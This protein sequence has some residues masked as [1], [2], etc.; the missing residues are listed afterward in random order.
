MSA[1]EPDQEPQKN[2]NWHQSPTAV[3]KKFAAVLKKNEEAQNHWLTRKEATDVLGCSAQTIVNHERK[4]HLNP[5]AAYRTDNR[6]AQ[7]KVLVYDPQELAKLAT[8]V[9]RH[10]V[11]PRE[12]GELAARAY[13][14]FDEGA[15]EKRIVKELRM[16]PD[17]ISTL[18]D[19]WRD[20]GGSDVVITE[21]AR[22]ELTKIVG[23]FETV[24]DLIEATKLLGSV[25]EK[26]LG[27]FQETVEFQDHLKELAKRIQNL[28]T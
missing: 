6:G 21:N 26:R 9:H 15:P 8:R 3:D 27:P 5:R 2:W 4:G 23:P 10:V 7:H 20:G 17:A 28:S 13:E 24:A 22:A 25:F 12:A 16:T 19:K 14:L 1:K 18:H 11:N